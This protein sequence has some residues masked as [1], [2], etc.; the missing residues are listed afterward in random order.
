MAKTRPP[1]HLVAAAPDDDVS[2]TLGVCAW[3]GSDTTPDGWC[4]RGQGY[5][6]V[7]RVGERLREV[8]PPFA[9]PLCRNPFP[10]TW[11]GACW[12][13]LGRTRLESPR[14]FPGA[15]HVFEDGHYRE[16]IPAGQPEST[17]EHAARA[18]AAMRAR[19]ARVVTR[20]RPPSGVV[21]LTSRRP[22]AL[23]V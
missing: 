4:P 9:C 16:E 6:A 8:L 5:A 18:F 3:D 10:L 12:T 11:N 15:G 13:C 19:V 14:T 23:L 21:E 2:F 20:G 1:K 17:P 22:S 7:V